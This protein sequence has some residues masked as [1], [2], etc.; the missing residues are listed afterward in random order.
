[1]QASTRVTELLTLVRQ[2]D[3]DSLEDL[4]PLV[5]GELRDLA[6]RNLRRERA[7]HTLQATALVHEAYLKL[8]REDKRD[9]ENRR[10]FLS[11]AATAMRRILVNHHH[12]HSAQKRGGGLHRVTLQEAVGLFE[13]RGQDLSALDEALKRLAELDESK[14]RIVELRFF[15]GLTVDEIAKVLEVSPSTVER[16]WRFSKAWLRRELNAG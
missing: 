10:H 9:W 1:M 16:A 14:S 13:D 12:Q 5:Y 4:F 6:N 7:D 15:G 2:G 3:R 8:V 11:V